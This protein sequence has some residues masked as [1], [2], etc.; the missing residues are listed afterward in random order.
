MSFGIDVNI[1]LYASDRDSPLHQKAAAFLEKC[2]GEGEVFCLAWMT[3]MSYLRIATHPSIFAKPLTHDMAAQNVDALLA[4]P[5]VRLI[6]EQ[7][8][9]WTVY[10]TLTDDA[11]CRGNGVPDAHLA[12]LLRHNG[13][14]T[15][16]TRDRDFRRFAFLDVRDPLA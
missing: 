3:L 12:A 14:R 2:A 7:E 10:R 9:F 8:G 5:H 11:P 15:L 6:G 16:F 4:L 13:V 1:L